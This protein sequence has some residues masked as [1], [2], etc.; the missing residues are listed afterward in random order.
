MEVVRN[1][2]AGAVAGAVGTVVMD[3]V[4]F[5]RY[6]LDGGK[7]SFR[8]WEAGVSILG[9]DQASA[10]GQ[11]GR[12]AL[13]AIGH[14]VDPPADWARSTTNVVH[15]A[16][17]VGWGVQYGLLASMTSRRP[18]LRALALGPAV[19]SVSYVLLP[20]AGVYQPI[21]KYDA[22]TL[23][24]DFSAHLIYGGAVSAVFALRPRSS[25]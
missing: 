1:I 24:K 6:R 11:V 16:A 25:D 22:R 13:R 10:P 21:W 2:V 3:A 4:W 15:W 9:W 12:K 17:G 7:D 19:W 14:G 20:L 8:R 23:G 5:R 18:W